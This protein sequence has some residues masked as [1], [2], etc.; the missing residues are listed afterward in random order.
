[1]WLF[2][3]WRAALH[4][5]SHTQCSTHWPRLEMPPKAGKRKGRSRE[6]IDDSDDPEDTGVSHLA[7]GATPFDRFSL[8]QKLRRLKGRKQVLMMM[9]K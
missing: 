8:R 6:F 3:A 1:M 5:C 9:T 2:A 7:L 4:F